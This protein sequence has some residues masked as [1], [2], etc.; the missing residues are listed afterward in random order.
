MGEYIHIGGPYS[1]HKT[2]CQRRL[3]EVRWV[4]PWNTDAY[5]EEWYCPEC[6]ASVFGPEEDE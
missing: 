2:F 4:E 5:A 1:T 6:W 3:S